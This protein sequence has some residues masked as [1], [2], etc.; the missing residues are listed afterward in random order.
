MVV[1]MSERNMRRLKG[2]LEEEWGLE[3]VRMSVV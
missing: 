3:P 1:V 2:Q